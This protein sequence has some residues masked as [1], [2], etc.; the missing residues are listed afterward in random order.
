MQ[1][2]VYLF[3]L[4]LLWV[5]SFNEEKNRFNPQ[6]HGFYII[7]VFFLRINEKKC[8]FFGTREGQKLFL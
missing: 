8:C 4:R 2:A 6:K 7:K 5:N 1:F 3:Q